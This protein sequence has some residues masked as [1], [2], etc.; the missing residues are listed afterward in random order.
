M[1]MTSHQNSISRMYTQDVSGL[2]RFCAPCNRRDIIQARLCQIAIHKFVNASRYLLRKFKRN[3]TKLAETKGRYDAAKSQAVALLQ[4]E[5][6]ALVA[7]IQ[8]LISEQP[9]GLSHAGSAA[10]TS[11]PPVPEL[12][13]EQRLLMLIEEFEAH[14]G[15]GAK[16]VTEEDNQVRPA[17]S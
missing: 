6:A 8:Q 5:Q 7:D 16:K 9:V 10:T 15:A 3:R 17:A 12:T 4:A 2:L 11:L 13:T 14:V 1:Y